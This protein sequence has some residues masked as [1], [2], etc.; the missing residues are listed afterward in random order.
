M[1]SS[2]WDSGSY[3]S[4]GTDVKYG[5]TTKVKGTLNASVYCSGGCCANKSSFC[6]SKTEY[7]MMGWSL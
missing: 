5:R 3:Q 7:K 4:N 6:N 1:Y 2:D